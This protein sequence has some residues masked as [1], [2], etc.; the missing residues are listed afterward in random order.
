MTNP[1]CSICKGEG[2]FYEHSTVETCWCSLPSQSKAERDVL[3]ELE[4]YK[5]QLRALIHISD[6]TGWE[7]HTCGEIA[8]ARALLAKEA[9]HA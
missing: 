1:N 3:A 6:A 8:K 2:V 4:A 7:R 9:N 5:S